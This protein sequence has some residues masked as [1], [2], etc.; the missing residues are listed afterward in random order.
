MA[1]PGR[2]RSPVGR[3]SS[4]PARWQVTSHHCLVDSVGRWII[5]VNSQFTGAR[6]KDST[7]SE[8][9]WTSES[10]SLERCM[11]SS[12]STASFAATATPSKSIVTTGTDPRR[13]G[14]RRCAGAHSPCLRARSRTNRTTSRSPSSS[15][16]SP[17]DR[18]RVGSQRQSSPRL[19]SP[20]TTRWRERS[21]SSCRQVHARGTPRAG[22]SLIHALIEGDL[23]VAGAR[24]YARRVAP[25]IPRRGSRYP[26][27]LLRAVPDP[28][29]QRN[30]R[31]LEC[32]SSGANSPD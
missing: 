16:F 25:S 14:A 2:R 13:P 28:R 10:V 31:K 23:V 5:T 19:A 20:F 7:S 26:T 6:K 30:A 18:L 9:I 21:V 22:S 4:R 1:W 8:Q 32:V 24:E 29:L 3:R 11:D 27:E 17:G 15:S 12:G